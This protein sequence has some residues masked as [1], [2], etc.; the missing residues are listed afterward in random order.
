[1]ELTDAEICAEQTT[2][3]IH[4]RMEFFFVKM[5]VLRSGLLSQIAECFFSA[6]L[7]KARLEKKLKLFYI[8]LYQMTKNCNWKKKKIKCFQFNYLPF[9]FSL[10]MLM[11]NCL[12]SF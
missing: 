10:M 2:T 11:G 6:I 8:K 12:L 1:M 5:C 9:L 4:R 3:N 7:L